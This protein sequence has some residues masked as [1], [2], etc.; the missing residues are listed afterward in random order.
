MDQSMFKGST[1][2]H[3]RS[4]D[5]IAAGAYPSKISSK[6]I[7][8]HSQDCMALHCSSSF[9]GFDKKS[10]INRNKGLGKV[11]EDMYQKSIGNR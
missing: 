9:N 3:P 7:I 1:R 4:S 11:R 2:L 6:P 8:P 5:D 10:L